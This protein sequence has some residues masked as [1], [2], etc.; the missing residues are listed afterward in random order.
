[1]TVRVPQSLAFAPVLFISLVVESTQT[2]ECLGRFLQQSSSSNPVCR[3][4]LA[5]FVLSRV[6]KLGQFENYTGHGGEGSL[7][8]ESW[9]WRRRPRRCR[10]AAGWTR[11]HQASFLPP[12]RIHQGIRTSSALRLNFGK[13]GGALARLGC[14]ARIVNTGAPGDMG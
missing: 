2:M 12:S 8:L 10:V 5:M 11:G 4:R 14:L 6:S 7:G 1:M 9:R 3:T 13:A